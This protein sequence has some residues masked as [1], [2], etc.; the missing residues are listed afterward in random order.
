[1]R[2]MKHLLAS[3]LSLSLTITP[4]LAVN[5][6]GS[7]FFQQG[8]NQ[9]T[10]ESHQTLLNQV[11][12]TPIGEQIAEYALGYLNFPYVDGGWTHDVGFD[13]AGFTKFVFY[14]FDLEVEHSVR[15]QYLLGEPV[16]KADLLPGD[17][18]IFGSISHLGIYIGDGKFIH[19]ATSTRKVCID[20][21]DTAFYTQYY[22]GAKRIFQ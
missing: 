4:A 1:M 10:L 11:P 21:L 18:L 3:V 22:Y 5:Q 12:E 8:V 7:S 6:S 2:H 20:S 13:C 15:S 14:A 9:K 19:S 17:L 16:E